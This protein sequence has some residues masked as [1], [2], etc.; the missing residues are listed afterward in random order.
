MIDSFAMV[1][2]RFIGISTC[3]ENLT[4]MGMYY[5]EQSGKVKSE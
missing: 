5:G 1:W 2:Q 3:S 4:K